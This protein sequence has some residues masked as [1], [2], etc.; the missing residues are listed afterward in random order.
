[1]A[2]DTYVRMTLNEFK[3]IKGEIDGLESS[4]G[5]VDEEAQKGIGKA[6]D[7]M[8]RV[9]KRNAELLAREGLAV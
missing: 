9:V 8:N 7:A 4:Y 6:V 5:G 3:A 2:K 1:M